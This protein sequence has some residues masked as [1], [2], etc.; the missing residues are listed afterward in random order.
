LSDR[1]SN[2]E[3]HILRNPIGYPPKT[4]QDTTG[5]EELKPLNIED[6]SDIL[7]AIDAQR[8]VNK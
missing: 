7:E 4:F 1:S 2:T 6:T 5:L 8:N 3:G